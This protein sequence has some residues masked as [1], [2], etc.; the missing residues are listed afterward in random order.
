MNKVQY[1]PIALF[2][3]NRPVHAQQTIDALKKNYLAGE[4]ELFI[5]SDG[6]KDK[7]A[8]ENVFKV[9]EYI[10]TITGF[11]RI[12][13]IE[14]DH[15]LGLSQSITTG[16]T[17]SV[18]RYGRVIVLEDDLV[19]APYFL[20][21]MNDYLLLY[22]DEERVISVC[23]YMYPLSKRHGDILFL[24][25]A[26]CWGWATWKRG[27]DLFAKDGKELYNSLKTRK[28]FRRF[29][30]DGAYDYVKMLERQIQGRNDSWA[31]RWY[32]SALL[33]GKLSLYPRRSLV[34]NIGFDGSGRHREHNDYFRIELLNEAIDIQRAPVFEDVRAIREIGFYLKKQHLC[35]A[36]EFFR[37]QCYNKRNKGDN[38][39]CRDN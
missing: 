32:A 6:P 26:D 36:L 23:A 1:A 14:R 5:F 31:V 19:T 16:V 39:A 10:K 13:I 38:N 4:S 37:K 12:T 24:R 15:N 22:Q 29:N 28:L 20:K 18:S 25:I 17:E 9:R 3:Y 11:K 33:N 21:F 27:W 2:V 34:M 7:A 30:L 35:K 8:E